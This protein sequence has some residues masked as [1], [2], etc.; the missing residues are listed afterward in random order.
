MKKILFHSDSSK[1]KTGYGRNARSVLQKLFESGK[2]EI[3]EYCTSPNRWEEEIDT[4]WKSYGC[5]PNNEILAVVPKEN[6][7]SVE[8]GSYYIN[9]LIEKEKPDVYIGVN[10]PW[11]FSGFSEKVWWNKIHS[12]LWVTPDS[13]PLYEPLIREAPKIKNLWVWSGFAEKELN[14]LGIESKTVHGAFDLNEFKIQ[15]KT[16]QGLPQDAYVFGFVFRNQL[17]KLVGSLFDAFKIAKK[18]MPNAKLLLHTCWTERGG[19]DIS[20]LI[21]NSGIDQK[22]V[23]VTYYCRNCKKIHF[24]NFSGEG[25]K[26][27]FCGENSCYTPTQTFGPSNSQMSEIYAS[28]DSY[29]HLATSGGL[30][31]PIVEALLCGKNVITVPYSFGEEFCDAGVA[32]PVEISFHREYDTQFLKAEPNASSVASVMIENYNGNGLK[33]PDYLREWACENFDVN[34]ICKEIENFVDSLPPVD[35][36]TYSIRPREYNIVPFESIVGEDDSEW[37]LD[38]I[39]KVFGGKENA[40]SDTIANVLSKIA[41]EG[42]E[43]VF[44]MAI[45][46]AKN[47]NEYFSLDLI[48]NYLKKQ[49]GNT[50]FIMPDNIS[51][52]IP[53]ISYLKAMAESEFENLVIIGND[54]SK[55]LSEQIPN[56]SFIPKTS[57]T[58][59]INFLNNTKSQNGEKK[60]KEILY[61]DENG[62]LLY[63]DTKSN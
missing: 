56:C 6:I 5:L 61:I 31:M 7:R 25:K 46:R 20:R 39:F 33:E 53:T 17:R 28:I 14:R 35:H 51:F 55:E 4:P 37:A 57:K 32:K 40:N 38:L 50:A 22:D 23:Y 26:C 1:R 18:S 45:S 30:E 34:K 8:Y 42:R 54:F 41:Q 24:A 9:E 63:V 2:Y 3:V 48:D 62:N 21:K 60:F 44:E 27:P 15:E 16:I 11:A 43:K 59:S 10:D 36:S 49:S 52:Q 58:S 47:N 19:W 29:V 12:V 13:L